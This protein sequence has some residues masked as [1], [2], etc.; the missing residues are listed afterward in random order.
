MGLS[1]GDQ[2]SLMKKP[3]SC[4]TVL[5]DLISM[6]NTSHYRDLYMVVPASL[7]D[8]LELNLK[9]IFDHVDIVHHSTIGSDSTDL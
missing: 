4:G 6:A 5:C 1:S 7:L 3:M 2:M 9:L 8:T